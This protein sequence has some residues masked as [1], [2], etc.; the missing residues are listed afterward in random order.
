V[1]YPST[2]TFVAISKR[3]AAA[4][5]A[6]TKTAVTGA[7]GSEGGEANPPPLYQTYY[8]DASNRDLW[9]DR[10]VSEGKSI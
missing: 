2:V 9:S 3:K 7:P 6:V 8:L 5:S 1:I 4:S 10:E